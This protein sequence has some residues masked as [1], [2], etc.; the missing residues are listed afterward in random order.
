MF[1]HFLVNATQ[2]LSL[3]IF[4]VA[5]GV[6]EV[7]EGQCD[8]KVGN[9]GIYSLEYDLDEHISIVSIWFKLKVCWPTDGYNYGQG[10]A[11]EQ[12][13]Y[14][15]NNELLGAGQLMRSLIV[16]LVLSFDYFLLF[17]IEETEKKCE[18]GV[19]IGYYC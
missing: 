12:K 1:Y 6:I 7:N 9:W 10:S 15:V 18:L 8:Q 5:L 16:S 4:D 14:P 19:C 13:D 17:L 3:F 2:N 11:D